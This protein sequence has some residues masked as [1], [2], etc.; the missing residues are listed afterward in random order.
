MDA[1]SLRIANTLIGN[2]PGDAGLEITMH[3]PV[4]RFCTDA[5]IALCGADLAPQISKCVVP[6]D[7]PVWVRGGSELEFSHAKLGC[8]AYLGVAGGCDVPDVLGSRGTY[9]RAGFGGIEGRALRAG[10]FVGFRPRSART[11]RI[12]QSLS[13]QTGALPFASVPWRTYSIPDQ[14]TTSITPIIR[15]TRGKQYS[16]FAEEQRKLFFDSEFEVTKNADRMGYRLQGPP[17]RRNGTDELLSEGMLPGTIQIPPDGQPIVM[18]VDCPVTGGYPKIAHV[19]QADLPVLAQVA[20]GTKLR[21]QEIDLVEA[22][23]LLRQ[24]ERDFRKLRTA[25]QLHAW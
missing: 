22:T 14:L 21:F 1:Q 17:I 8:R 20:P 18:A 12:F 16:W 13:A 10:D 5:L 6:L 3:G 2:E 19:V 25:L 11:E 24:R 7:R 4:L 9:F 23:D 15:A